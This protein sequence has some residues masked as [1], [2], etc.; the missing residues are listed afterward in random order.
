MNG[1]R[2]VHV[3]TPSS[4]FKEWIT[5]EVCFHNFAD[6]STETDEREASPEFSSLGHEWILDLYP[7]GAEISDEG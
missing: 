7:G 3:G 4:S 5:T 1:S 6:L 2:I